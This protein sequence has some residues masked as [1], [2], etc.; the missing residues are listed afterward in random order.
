VRWGS[1]G[2]GDLFAENHG[3]RRKWCAGLLVEQHGMGVCHGQYITSHH[4]VS[5]SSPSSS[6][7]FLPLGCWRSMHAHLVNGG[8]ENH[9][10]SFNSLRTVCFAAKH[11]ADCFLLL[12]MSMMMMKLVAGFPLLHT[13]HRSVGGGIGV[14][15]GRPAWPGP[16]PKKPGTFKPCLHR[17]LYRC[18]QLPSVAFVF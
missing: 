12:M 7:Q 16:S 3:L 18:R 4:V 9:R 2:D 1:E 13:H 14:H 15:S 17:P 10:A 11:T 6:S 8:S 5:F